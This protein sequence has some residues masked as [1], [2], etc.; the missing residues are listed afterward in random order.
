[1]KD[2]GPKPNIEFHYHIQE[3]IE[4]QRIRSDDR[5]YHRQRIK[6]LDDREDLIKDSKEFILT[7][8]WCDKCKQDF[9]AVAVRQIEVDWSN[10][11]Q[12]IAFYKTKCFKGHWVIRL[13]TDRHVDAFY[14]KSKLLALDRGNHYADTVQPFESGFNL[15]YGKK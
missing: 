12:R 11:S 9:K 2:Y 1:M 4:R 15:L 5:E 13:I 3:L 7:D 6:T 8:F 14:A 10:S